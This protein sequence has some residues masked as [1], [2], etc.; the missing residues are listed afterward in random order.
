LIYQEALFTGEFE[1]YVKKEAVWK[2][3]TLCIGAPLGN[4]EEG[5]LTGNFERQ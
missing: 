5:L 4:L 3:A 2:T 1:R